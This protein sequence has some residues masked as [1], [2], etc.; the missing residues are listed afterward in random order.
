MGNNNSPQ[1]GSNQKVLSKNAIAGIVIGTILAAGLVIGLAVYFGNK[2][3]NPSFWIESPVPDVN[4]TGRSFYPGESQKPSPIKSDTVQPQPSSN[5]CVCADDDDWVYD[6]HYGLS[7][8]DSVA[9][10]P[11]YCTTLY[12]NDNPSCLG[13]GR[14]DKSCNFCYADKMIPVSV[15]TSLTCTEFIE[16]SVTSGVTKQ[17]ICDT[18]FCEKCTYPHYC[19]NVCGFC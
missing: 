19:D 4:P 9:T 11:S 10:R 17:E 8:A 3:S 12:C 18:L 14:C 1:N 5:M 6:N 16:D 13:A 15:D 7:C 2:K